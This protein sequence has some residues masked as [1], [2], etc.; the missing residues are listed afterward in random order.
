MGYMLTGSAGSGVAGLPFLAF[1]PSA[2]SQKAAACT[3]GTTRSRGPRGAK[4][5]GTDRFG[6]ASSGGYQSAQVQTVLCSSLAG[7]HRKR[8]SGAR[9]NSLGNIINVSSLFPASTQRVK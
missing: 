2:R 9:V 6:G 1:G 7:K 8:D 5:Q 3:F 4:G